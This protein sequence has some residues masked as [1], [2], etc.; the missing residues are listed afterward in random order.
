MPTINVSSDNIHTPETPR[1]DT[2]GDGDGVER[3]ADVTTTTTEDITIKYPV[4][5]Q[6]FDA[7]T[8]D[9]FID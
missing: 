7:P 8:P 4:S 1:T 5:I 3:T 6:D 2:D 9:P